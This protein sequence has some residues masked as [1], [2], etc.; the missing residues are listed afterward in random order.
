[1]REQSAPGEVEQRV[2]R[3]LVMRRLAILAAL[4][5]LLGLAPGATRADRPRGGTQ[6]A[7]PLPQLDDDADPIAEGGLDALAEAEA[8]AR[9]ERALRGPPPPDLPVREGEAL[10]APSGVRE[11]AHAVDVTLDD[12]LAIATHTLRFTST[13]RVPTEV[14]YRLAVPP[15]AWLA[16]L[17]VC[18]ASDCREGD[19]RGSA[20]AAAYD[21]AVRAR[22]AQRATGPSVV[23]HAQRMDDARGSAITLRAAPVVADAELT[24]RVRW[25]ARA[26]VHHGIARIV[27]PARGQDPRAA[28]AHVTVQAPRMLAATA[29]GLTTD[30]APVTVEPWFTSELAASLP[31]G[32]P[33]TASAWRVRCGAQ[34]RA[35]VRVASGSR[36][37]APVEIVLLVDASPS[38]LGPARGRLE[39]AIAALLAAAPPGSR[40]RA[41]AFG[42]RAETVL[43]ESV[44][45]G[46][47]PLVP[48]A[49]ATQTELGSATR[50]E[51]AWQ[52]VEPWIAQSGRSLAPLLVLVGDGGLSEGAETDRAL[53]AIVASRVPFSV[54]DVG[55]RA[56]VA[57]LVEASQRSGGVVVLAPPHDP[58]AAKLD[59]RIAEIFAPIVAQEVVVHDGARVVRLGALRAGEERTLTL[60]S[61]SGAVRISA[62]RV[63]A[64]ARNARE[65]LATA[66]ALGLAPDE[67]PQ[68]LAAVALPVALRGARGPSPALRDADGRAPAACLPYGPATHPS[69]VSSDLAPVALA[70]PRSC[71]ATFASDAEAREPGELRSAPPSNPLDGRGVPAETLLAMLRSRVV[72]AARACFR[73][74]R[75]GRADYS[76]RAGIAFALADREILSTDITGELTPA[77]RSCL[78]DAVER[79][80]V[81]RF[82]GTVVVRYPVYTEAAP[83]PPTIELS[84]GAARGVDRTFG[85]GVRIEDVRALRR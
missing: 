25:V 31:S 68:A 46:S 24:V 41:V 35:R 39:P 23:A 36:A 17:E 74:D 12:G 44:E 43:G 55:D 16:G 83:P 6:A 4:A 21:D 2:T 11:S 5:A 71:R 53:A 34:S 76:V 49:Q 57:R 69:G 27:L 33:L 73:A 75:A 63:T 22:P 26:A 72:P 9:R 10:T 58:D 29:D 51:T 62:A 79:L 80:E 40:V 1:M 13:A 42:G 52:L 45:T 66:L 85:S 67:A 20:G 84:G 54:I 60:A 59:E 70:E 37:G 38:T 32:A 48:L 82:E 64:T 30:D 28:A 50:I 78:L 47:A 65:P 8:R 15:G 81:P 18:D 7:P 3:S 56:P 14:R 77:L 19:V 61:S